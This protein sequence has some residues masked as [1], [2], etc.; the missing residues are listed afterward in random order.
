MANWKWVL[1][2]VTVW[3]LWIPACAGMTVAQGLTGVLPLR[4]TTYPVLCE[5]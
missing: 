1:C 3:I 2:L 4:V 5:N